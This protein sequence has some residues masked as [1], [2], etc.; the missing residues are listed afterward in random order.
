MM[1]KKILI[2]IAIFL[3]II[4]SICSV[5]LADEDFGVNSTDT[6]ISSEEEAEIAEQLYFNK[7]DI[8]ESNYYGFK[9]DITL[10][11]NIING[12]AFVGG[13]NVTLKDVTVNGDIFIIANNLTISAEAT[14]NGNVF[15]CASNVNCGGKIARELYAVCKEIVFEENFTIMYN[16]NVYADHIVTKGTFY[17]NLNT[18]ITN[19]EITDGT[20]IYGTL[21]YTSEKEATIGDNAVV[22]DINFSKYVEEEETILDIITD[23]VLDFAKYFVLTMVVF[24][25]A[26]KFLPGLFEK[27]KKNLSI[28]S[29]GIGIASIILIPIIL[30]LLLMLRVFNTVVFAALALFILILLISMSIANIAIASL[31]SD[32]KPKLKLPISVPLVTAI[33]WIIYQIPYIGAI[34]SFV[35]ITTGLGVSVKNCFT[36]KVL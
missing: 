18:A 21:N 23:K 34:A 26:M 1:K 2:A 32:K 35:W 15:I 3:L 4:V 22:R 25:I 8:S 31:I 12:N 36:K 16:A 6:E 30:I 17:R 7:K 13:S 14:L 28:N 10:E 27:S 11:G 5:V 29:F 19:F 9:E 24:I 20:V 33:S